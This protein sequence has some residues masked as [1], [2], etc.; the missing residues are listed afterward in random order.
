MKGIQKFVLPKMARN[1]SCT[2]SSFVLH[3]NGPIEACSRGIGW[4]VLKIGKNG[5]A[6]GPTM[7]KK[8]LVH[9]ILG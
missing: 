3:L 1:I 4:V 8:I 7:S 5:A 6:S 2:T 9:A